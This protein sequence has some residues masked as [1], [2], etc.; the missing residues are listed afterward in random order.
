[1]QLTAIIFDLWPINCNLSHL[2]LFMVFWNGDEWPNP[3]H[4]TIFRNI[5][6]H[7]IPS[8]CLKHKGFQHQYYREHVLSQESCPSSPGFSAAQVRYLVNL[9]FKTFSWNEHLILHISTPP[10]YNCFVLPFSK[11]PLGTIA[12]GRCCQMFSDAARCSQ[13]LPDDPRCPRW[14]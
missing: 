12:S 6:F 5:S 2:L 3:G 4:G 13:M 9:A 7:F 14:S 10:I 11:K 8:I 1:M